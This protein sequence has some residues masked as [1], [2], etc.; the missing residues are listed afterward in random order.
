MIQKETGGIEALS[1]ENSINP[2]IT[3]SEFLK[4]AHKV[5]L[6]SGLLGEGSVHGDICRAILV[7]TVFSEMVRKER[8]EEGIVEKKSG[9]GEP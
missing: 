5:V 3:Y 9:R 4:R 1:R 6:R 2:D 7:A 8:Q